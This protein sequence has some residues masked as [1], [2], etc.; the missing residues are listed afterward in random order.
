MNLRTWGQARTFAAWWHPL[1]GGRWINEP[2]STKHI[3]KWAKTYWKYWR[4][5]KKHAFSALCSCCELDWKG[6]R[7]ETLL[8]IHHHHI[9]QLTLLVRTLSLSRLR[10]APIFHKLN[11]FRDPITKSWNPSNKNDICMRRLSGSSSRMVYNVFTL[12]IDFATCQTLLL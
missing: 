9:L 3:E 5:L 7:V 1:K 6:R 10:P 2:C 4:Y 12:W 11:L 8:S